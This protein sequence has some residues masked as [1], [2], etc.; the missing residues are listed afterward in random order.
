ML[1]SPVLANHLKS[2]QVRFALIG[3]V[4]LAV[5]GV[6]RYT[7]DVDLLTLD[8]RVLAPSFW[9][10]LEL[11]K[12]R[13]RIGEIDDPLGGV[14]RFSIDPPHDLIVGKGHAA[15]IALEQCKEIESLPCFAADSLGLILLKLEAGSPQDAFDILALMNT[16]MWLGQDGLAQTIE[17][18]LPKLSSTAQRF[19]QKIQSLS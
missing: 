16:G 2:Q 4:A 17:D 12:P 14:V 19:W 18:H 8:T 11:P 6:A 15:Q 9:K 1:V 3:G 13:I 10:D 7:A 5:W